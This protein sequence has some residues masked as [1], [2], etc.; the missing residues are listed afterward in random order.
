MN[1][2]ELLT[3]KLDVFETILMFSIFFIFLLRINV[4]IFSF[5]PLSFLYKLFVVLFAILLV[6]RVFVIKDKK[7]VKNKHLLFIVVFYLFLVVSTFLNSNTLD[8]MSITHLADTFVYLVIFFYITITSSNNK[9]RFNVMA[10]SYLVVCT[11]MS[12]I[13]LFIF[14]YDIDLTI[15]GT[16][17]PQNDIRL[18]NIWVNSN[19]AGIHAAL[20][21]VIAMYYLL[22]NEKNTIIRKITSLLVILIN[23]FVL[24][25][26]NSRTSILIVIVIVISYILRFLSINVKSKKIVGIITMI[27]LFMFF[28][29]SFLIVKNSIFLRY[30]SFKILNDKSLHDILNIIT[31]ERLIIWERVFTISNGWHI[32]FGNGIASF[33]KLLILANDP[34]EIISTHNLYLDIYVSIGIIGVTISLIYTVYIAVLFI[35]SC[36]KIILSNE[37]MVLISIVIAV[38]IFSLLDRGVLFIS[39]AYNCMFWFAL[40]ALIRNISVKRVKKLK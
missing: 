27:F 35:K 7:I 25:Y 21:I 31:S 29:G 23:C 26:S 37:N 40:G 10:I 18:D 22:N 32:W 12:I 28:I 6:I 33:E 15:F 19:V 30:G 14:K 5:L 39:R 2:Q 13:S 1:N 11:I 8:S 16:A 34:I 36:K 3:K 20:A 4:S 9:K 38:F 17:V 24:I